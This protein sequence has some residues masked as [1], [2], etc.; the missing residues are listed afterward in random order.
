MPEDSID[1]VLVSSPQLAAYEQFIVAERQRTTSRDYLFLEQ[2]P[3]FEPRR[4]D[5]V[6]PL[7]GL[8]VRDR[9]GSVRLVSESPRADVPIP[10][11]S[12]R[13]VERVLAALDG[14]RSLAEVSW[15]VDRAAL[16]SV[17]RHAFGLVLFAPG[18]I[19]PLEDRLS[20][21][22]VV[23]Y[24]S[25]PYAVERAYWENM[26]D[27]RDH[28][29]ARVD[30]VESLEAFSRLLRRLHVVALMG[31]GLDRF[32]KPASPASDEGA[33]PGHFWTSV[34]RVLETSR[35]TVYLDGPRVLSPAVGG[36]RFFA[37]LA[38]ALGDPDAISP[39]RDSHWGRLVLAR[40]ERDDAHKPWFLPARPLDDARLDGLREALSESLRLAA[41]DPAGAVR[42]AAR[43]H[44]RYVRAHPFRCANQSVAMTIVNEILRRANAAPIPHLALD[45]LALRFGQAAYAI[46]FERAVAAHAGE[47]GSPA[48]RL[49]LLSRAARSALALMD[50]V[51]G[52]PSEAAADDVVAKSP[53]AAVLALLRP[54]GKSDG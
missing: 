24:P 54:A 22:S 27:V 6:V 40:G 20:S 10:A 5:V 28:F 46:A 9:S 48:A 38:A 2:K 37:R 32:Y 52:A 21:S 3:R 41:T 33:S 35:G 34:S 43:F 49:A 19:G 25:S 16:V 12:R 30:A 26:I 15:N 7:P 11:T 14:E 18:A 51:S 8:S 47:Q 42:A 13:E 29:V 39:R 53:E 1:L 31:R 50:A 23:R 17:L 36:E 45:H 4:E 44:Y